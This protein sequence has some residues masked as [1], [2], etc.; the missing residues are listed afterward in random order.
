MKL[1]SGTC[2]LLM[3]PALLAADPSERRTAWPDAPPGFHWDKLGPRTDAIDAANYAAT[4]HVALSGSDE[5]GDGSATRPW[6]SIRK[7]LA[8]AATEGR[9][10]VLVAAGT[11]KE[12]THSMQ[13]RVDLFG[14]FESAGWTRDIVKNPTVLSGGGTGRILIGADDAKLDGFIVEDGSFR[15]HGGAIYCESTSPT[16]TNNVFRRNRTLEPEGFTHDKSRRRMRGLD[17]GAIGLVNYANA[18]IRNNLFQANETEIGYGGAIGASHDCIPIIA[19]NVFWANRAGVN[20]RNET[21]S[22]NGGAVSLLFSSRAAIFHNLFVENDALGGSDGGALFMEYFCWP[23][24]RNNAFLNNHAGDDGGALDNQKFSYPKLRANLFYGNRADGSGAGFHLDDAVIEMENNVFA[25]NR[26][27]K[28]AGG[29]GGTHGWY[30]ALNNTV[31]YNEAGRDGGGIHIVNVKNPFLRPPVFRNNLVVFN[32]PEQV[33]LEG[34]VDVTYNIM[35]PGGSKAGY[36]NFDLEPGF[37]DDSFRLDASAARQDPGTFTTTLVVGDSLE[38]GALTGRIVR[39]GAFWSMVKS[40]TTSALTVWGLMPE[41][42]GRSIEVVQT[43]HVGPESLAVSK[44]VYPD[45]AQEDIDGEPRYT[46]DVDIGADE[47]HETPIGRK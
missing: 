6:R 26:A 21:L 27:E 41:D 36:Y 23:E 1:R 28:Q 34:D 42:A 17:G 45:F 39:V 13:A 8:S 16:I 32:K 5:R 44:G 2:L 19:H 4:L 15:G 9:T 12:G 31:A 40:N 3:L 10:A 47:Y 22:G 46:P 20:D 7:A 29:F 35:H 37:I 30:R 38:S 33:L 24:I 18:D 43:F 14:G 25:Y 11:Y